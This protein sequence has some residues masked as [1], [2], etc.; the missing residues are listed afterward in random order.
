MGRAAFITYCISWVAE[1]LLSAQ[2]T[3]P[4]HTAGANPL[5]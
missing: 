1:T 3:A 5:Q 2:T 4:A